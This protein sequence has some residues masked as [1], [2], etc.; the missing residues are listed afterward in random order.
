MKNRYAGFSA[1][2]M[3]VVVAIIAILAMIAIPT[4]MGRI[5]KENVVAALPLADAAK[6]PIA[7]AWK[8]TKTLPADNKEAGLPAPEKVVSNF[9][10]ALEVQ[11]GVIHMTFGNKAHSKI[12]GKVLTLRPAVIEESQAVPI[13]WVCGNAKVPDQ[14]AVKGENRTNIP[15]EYLPIL[16]R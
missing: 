2:E 10:S 8:T 14:M 7:A 16:C 5:I 12:K 6:E 3:M 1:M 9:I 13:A 4:S 15:D 11:N